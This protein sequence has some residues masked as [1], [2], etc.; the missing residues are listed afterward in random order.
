M[1]QALASVFSALL[2]PILIIVICLVAIIGWTA[3]YDS[4]P[5]YATSTEQ[6]FTDKVENNNCYEF[7]SKDGF[8]ID[9]NKEYED[10]Q[11]D[12]YL[13]NFVSHSQTSKFVEVLPSANALNHGTDVGEEGAS[14]PTLVSPLYNPRYQDFLDNE[15]HRLKVTVYRPYV[16][17]NPSG[18]DANNPEPL[19]NPILNN[20]EVAQTDNRIPCKYLENKVNCLAENPTDP[21][22]VATDEKT[23][24]IDGEEVIEIHM[25][26]NRNNS[27][28]VIARHR[29][30][31]DYYSALWYKTLNFSS[32]KLDNSIKL[33]LEKG[34]FGGLYV[35]VKSYRAGLGDKYFV[36]FIAEDVGSK[37]EFDD[38]TVEPWG[39]NTSDAIT[40]ADN[41]YIPN[42]QLN[43]PNNP[44]AVKIKVKFDE[45][46][47]ANDDFSLNYRTDVLD[48]VEVRLKNNKNGENK[49]IAAYPRINK[50][51]NEWSEIIPFE[52]INEEFNIKKALMAGQFIGLYVKIYDATHLPSTSKYEVSFSLSKTQSP[53]IDQESEIDNSVDVQDE[54]RKVYPFQIA[55]RGSKSIVRET[56]L[57]PYTT[58]IKKFNYDN[59]RLATNLDYPMTISDDDFVY[60]PKKTPMPSNEAYWDNLNFTKRRDIKITVKNVN[61]GCTHDEGGDCYSWSTDWTS[62]V[63]VWPI[64]F[65]TNGDYEDISSGNRMEVCGEITSHN[66]GS[67][68]ADIEKEI[69]VP[70][71]KIETAIANGTYKSISLMVDN[72][73]NVREVDLDI[74]YAL[75]DFAASAEEVTYDQKVMDWPTG[76]S[77][78]HPK[79][80][81][82]QADG[83]VNVNSVLY[84]VG[85]YSYHILAEDEAT[86][87]SQYPTDS[88][89]QWPEDL[90]ECD[91]DPETGD[92]IFTPDCKYANG[93]EPNTDEDYPD[94][95][96][97]DGHTVRGDVNLIDPVFI[98][99]TVYARSGHYQDIDDWL[100]EIE[101]PNN[102]DSD[103]IYSNWQ[104]R[105]DIDPE[106]NTKP[107]GSDGI[108]YY[109]KHPTDKSTS[110][111]WPFTQDEIPG[112]DVDGNGS[113][114]KNVDIA[115]SWI[116]YMMDLTSPPSLN[117]EDSQGEP[118]AGGP[119]FPIPGISQKTISGTQHINA[120][121][122]VFFEFPNAD[123]TKMQGH[124][125][126]AIDDQNNYD[127]FTVIEQDPDSPQRHVYKYDPTTVKAV[128]KIDNYNEE[129]P[130][131]ISG[132]S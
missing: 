57:G 86:A 2:F 22:I 114:A 7:D 58:Y 45:S 122:I 49:V 42:Y 108:P 68:G 80:E 10:V 81:K 32:K 51:S 55:V 106:A 25:R 118:V 127:E 94:D 87:R 100:Y 98:R 19:S 52:S 77:L 128:Y 70:Y 131:E 39:A 53:Q 63:T 54:E 66:Q 4:A 61:D 9:H 95:S 17:A 21:N 96:D 117:I 105:N 41:F 43:D 15:E 72:N 103:T 112:I 130:D 93:T 64:M 129:D 12:S 113:G 119:N 62:R 28:V 111:W 29:F 27:D 74:T 24:S 6:N 1:G 109:I 107:A 78:D 44:N 126:V 14:V 71:T 47:P 92:V 31:K 35:V 121:D 101:D 8:F 76:I 16:N 84:S 18:Y 13:K 38:E 125:G 5:T 59:W 65:K 26:N 60:L 67:C 11:D 73:A 20:F 116:M 91:K 50:T 46:T 33:A 120:G 132:V 88:K 69:I 3:K 75:S 48:F 40:T 79:T 110:S 90:A 34:Y 89:I 30:E 36:N 124:V 23:Q 83:S 85:G 102:W 99:C 82:L 123:N 56:K 104:T 37:I 97:D 115:K